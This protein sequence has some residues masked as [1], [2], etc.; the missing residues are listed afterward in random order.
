MSS[1]GSKSTEVSLYISFCFEPS[2]IWKVVRGR[3]AQGGTGEVENA[4][5]RYHGKVAVTQGGKRDYA[6]G[7][8][9][10]NIFGIT[11]KYERLKLN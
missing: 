9:V 1:I 8:I 10:V 6:F 3:S 5:M 11:F 7:D 4:R 2:P